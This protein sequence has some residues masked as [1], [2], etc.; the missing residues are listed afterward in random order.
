MALA[1]WSSSDGVGTGDLAV[2]DDL[3]ERG[4]AE[5]LLGGLR[6][7]RSTAEPPSEICEALPA[8]ML[9]AL[10][11]AGRSAPR[12]LDGG[13][14]S[15]AFVL[16]DDDRVTLALGDLDRDDLVVEQAVLLGLGRPLVASAARA[17]WDSRDRPAVAA[18]FSVP[19]P[20]AHWS[21]AQNSPSY[22]IESTTVLSPMR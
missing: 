3:A 8:V 4:D 13:G 7:T 21:K 20:M 14:R 18:Y 2:A 6:S 1:G 5:A 19:A 9:P 15:H 16:A 10:S 22:I 11:N 12:R 17:S